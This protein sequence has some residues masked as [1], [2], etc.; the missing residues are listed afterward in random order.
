M[1]ILYRAE[2]KAVAG[3]APLMYWSLSPEGRKDFEL[4]FAASGTKD[5][6]SAT[7]RIVP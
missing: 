2:A 1:D 3:I 6:H 5:I 7:F 4:K